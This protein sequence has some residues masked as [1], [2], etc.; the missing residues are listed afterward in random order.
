MK[1]V[2]IGKK[3]IK[4]IVKNEESLDGESQW[5]FS[6]IIRTENYVYILE[7]TTKEND[8]GKLSNTPSEVIVLDWDLNYKQSFQL[9]NYTLNFCYDTQLNRVFYSAYKEEGGTDLDYFD[10][11]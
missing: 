3:E 2:Q 8:F 7:Q 6:D 4:P 9:S 10:V 11:D 1:T 5:C